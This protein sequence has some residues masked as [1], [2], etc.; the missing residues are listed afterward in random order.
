MRVGI[1]GHGEIGKA[2]HEVYRKS[3]LTSD[4]LVKDLNRDDHLVDLDVLNVS[5]PFN[6]SFD[7][8]EVV[9]GVVKQSNTRIL[10]VHSTIPVGTTRKLKEL[11]GPA[12]AVAHSPCRGVHPHLYEGIMTFPKYVGSISKEDAVKVS[13]HLTSLGISTHICENSESSE[14]A[15]L[16]DTS[17][18]GICIA[19]HG[20]ALRACKQF[21]A[22]FED[23]MTVY[24][25]TYNSGYSSLGKTNVVRPVLTPPEEGIGGHCVVQNADLLMKQFDSK[26]LELITDYRKKLK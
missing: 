9:C 1:L 10:I 5:I 22:N 17:Y 6:D 19:F 24:N 25:E 11:L 12:I 3:S 2:I 20:E 16:L 8:M 14:L 26:A 15:K 7:F 4:I 18:Y 13:D 21:G 23:V